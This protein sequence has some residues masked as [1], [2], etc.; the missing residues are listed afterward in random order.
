MVPKIKTSTVSLYRTLKT[1]KQR[2]TKILS[3]V[4]TV[5]GDEEDD[6][7]LL[8]IRKEGLNELRESYF[9]M[10][11][12]L[13]GL[14][15]EDEVAAIETAG[16]EFQDLL[17]EIMFEIKRNIN[18]LSNQSEPKSTLDTSNAQITPCHGSQ[19]KLPDIQLPGFS[20]QYE[21]WLHFRDQF[22]NLIRRNESLNEQQRLHYLRS[23]LF[24]EA[25]LIETPE[26]SFSSLWRAL[27]SRYEN[28][29][30]LVDRH[31]AEIF[32]L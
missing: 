3:F 19:I 10:Q 16:E 15:K 30:W 31:L 14:V 17:K 25:A 32:L 27:E 29:L 7:L 23:C 21:E 2:A 8:E 28:R 24:G 11:G 6:V 13:F 26:E 4:N 5:K 18:S 20:G 22:N 1:L 12:K 9:E